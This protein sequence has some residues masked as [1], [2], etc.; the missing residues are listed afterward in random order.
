MATRTRPSPCEGFGRAA[1]PTTRATSTRRGDRSGRPQIESEIRLF[2]DGAEVFRSAPRPVD[3][4]P[5][6]TEL[7]A[8]GVLKFGPETPP[9]SYLLQIT[10]TDRLAKR[11]GR[12]TQTIDFD[13]IE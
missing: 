10:V 13:V 5:Q 1:R 9:G 12:A 4:A 11:D 7:L 8:G 3:A 6:A 2:R